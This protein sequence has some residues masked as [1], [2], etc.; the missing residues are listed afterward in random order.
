MILLSCSNL[1]F[2]LRI[3]AYIFK[4]F[5]FVVPFIII[6]M[7]AIDFLK[8]FFRPD[9]KSSHELMARCG[10]RLLYALI[11]FLIPVVVRIIFR[12]IEEISPKGYGTDNS[13]TSWI[14]CFNQY[15]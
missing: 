14:E 10:K 1:D 15:F 2:I 12:A 13:A 3:V 6:I 8:T 7:V 11:I 4:F 9:D 5:Q